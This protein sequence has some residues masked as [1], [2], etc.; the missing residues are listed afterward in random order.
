MLLKVFN[1]YFKII[2]HNATHLKSENYFPFKI[3]F[4]LCLLHERVSPWSQPILVP[5]Q[6]SCLL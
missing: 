4:V 2:V 3:Y 6:M 1:K 5:N